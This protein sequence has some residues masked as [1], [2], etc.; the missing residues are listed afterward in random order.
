MVGQAAWRHAR[1]AILLVAASD[2][3]AVATVQSGVELDPMQHP[4][5]LGAP[6]EAVA[7]IQEVQPEC[8]T[9]LTSALAVFFT[10]PS[11]TAALAAILG[12]VA[13]RVVTGGPPMIADAAVAL[14]ACGLWLVQEW[15]I[16]KYLLH[17]PFSWL[18]ECA[19]AAAGIMN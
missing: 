1:P 3:S 6:A 16:H 10:S 15:A 14:C 9:N 17:A 4:A 7:R 5:E 8:P 2:R 13:W 18:G 11:V 19:H 12:A